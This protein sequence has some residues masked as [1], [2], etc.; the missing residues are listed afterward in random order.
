MAN[1][2][3]IDMSKNRFYF[4]RDRKLFADIEGAVRHL[5]SE[6]GTTKERARMIINQGAVLGS[7]NLDIAIT[8]HH[9]TINDGT[10]GEME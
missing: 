6:Y 7:I 3:E 5:V 8:N 10:V 4:Q 9:R 2:L 1:Y